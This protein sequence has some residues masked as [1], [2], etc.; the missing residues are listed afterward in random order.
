MAKDLPYFKFFCSEW[1]DG[2]ITLEDYEVQ[3]LF[4]NICSYY[5]S[6][7]CKLTLKTLKKKFKRCDDLI[8]TLIDENLLVINDKTESITIKFLDEQLGER[9]KL[10]KQNSENALKRWADKKAQC[11]T[12]AVALIPHSE[13]GTE[14]MQYREE[15][16]REEER[17]EEKKREDIKKTPVFNFRKS[18]IDNGGNES[19]VIEFLKVR[20]A[21]KA[22]NSQIAFNAFM[23]KVNKSNRDIN[24]ILQ[25]CCEKSWK[26]YDDEW[27]KNEPMTKTKSIEEIQSQVC[28]S[29]KH[30]PGIKRYVDKDKAEAFFINQKTGGYVAVIKSN[31]K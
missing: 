30:E 8:N 3:G 16:K 22:V 4:I 21:K 24:N 1:N 5:W 13:S 27:A 11:G 7:E 20:K 15:K 25:I 12:D 31:G 28:Y 19:L 14:N 26:S 9:G 29:W 17:R 23:N 10:S 6:N 18:L 2:K